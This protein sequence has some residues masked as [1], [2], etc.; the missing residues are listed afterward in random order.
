VAAIIAAR[1][2]LT[3]CRKAAEKGEPWPANSL[4]EIKV[5]PQKIMVS[6]SLM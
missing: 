1:P 6:N 5:P 3:D 4:P 2:A